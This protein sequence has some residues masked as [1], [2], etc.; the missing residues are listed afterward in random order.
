[1]SLTDNHNKRKHIRALQR[2]YPYETPI[3]VRQVCDLCYADSLTFDCYRPLAYRVRHEEDARAQTVLV[4]L[5]DEPFLADKKLVAPFAMD[6]AKRGLTVFV[7]DL[8]QPR[9]NLFYDQ[10]DRLFLFLSS[11]RVDRSGLGVVLRTPEQEGASLVLMGLGSGALLAGVCLQLHGN[12]AMRRHFSLHCPAVRRYFA[13]GDTPDVD[14]SCIPS[15]SG[16]VSV[17]G[18]V[19]LPLCSQ[20]HDYAPWFGVKN[21][22]KLYDW[23][24]LYRHFDLTVPPV[25][26]TATEGDDACRQA[27]FLCDALQGVGA[28]CRVILSPKKDDQKRE[29][30]PLFNVYYPLWPLAKDLND[31]IAAF[32]KGFERE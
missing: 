3:N 15:P 25:L 18:L 1:M 27:R 11:L 28:A 30:E 9:S 31:Q 16:F 5:P 23:L 8:C 6:M 17:G 2:L 29:S 7:P 22:D 24:Q 32:C 10:I 14:F 13:M 12:Y 4:V 21:N 19:H 26:F 20:K